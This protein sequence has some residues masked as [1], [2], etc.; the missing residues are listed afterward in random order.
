MSVAIAPIEFS[1]SDNRFLGIGSMHRFDAQV[2][3]IV[4]IVGNVSSLNTALLDGF[5]CIAPMN[6]SIPAVAICFCQ[7]PSGFLFKFGL[8]F[9][10]VLSRGFL[11][12]SSFIPVNSSCA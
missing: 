1:V 10:L 8:K 6:R 7:L 2:P 4:R 11:C 5:R 12:F 3:C 9:G